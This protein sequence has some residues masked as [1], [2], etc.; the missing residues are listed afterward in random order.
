MVSKKQETCEKD[1]KNPA[2]EKAAFAA[3]GCGK[4]VKEQKA[5]KD[6]DYKYGKIQGEYIFP[7]DG[8]I[9]IV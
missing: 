5:R 9:G 8:G 3:A 1:A 2:N 6:A 7:Q 4:T